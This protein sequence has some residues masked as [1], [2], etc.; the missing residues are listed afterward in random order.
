LLYGV[1]NR[2]SGMWLGNEYGK[3]EGE[4]W[5][6]NV[7]CDGTETNLGDCRH[8]GWGQ[9]DCGHHQDVSIS[10]D[11]GTFSLYSFAETFMVA[12]NAAQ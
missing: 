11:T 4:I 10:C 3:G 6:D 7:Q 9:N 1:L 5:L 2:R 8:R 12:I